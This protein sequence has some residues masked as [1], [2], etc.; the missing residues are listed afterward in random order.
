MGKEQE[1]PMDGQRRIV[2]VGDSLLMDAVEASLN[3]SL[4]LGLLRIHGTP[5]QTAERLKNLAPDL[6]IFDM[7]TPHLQSIVPLLKEHPQ[8]RMLGLDAQSSQVVA[9]SG[10]PYTTP[11][12]SDLASLIFE[13][14]SGA[15]ELVSPQGIAAPRQRQ[16]G[17][18][19]HSFA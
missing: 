7:N 10:Q 13:G 2:L 4:K 9:L 8:V 19:L 6:V 18:P 3:D 16:G 15:N 17:V 12:A 14:S 5:A 1:R 11:S